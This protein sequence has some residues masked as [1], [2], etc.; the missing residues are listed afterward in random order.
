MQYLLPVQF[1]KACGL[2]VV[3]LEL[4][5]IVKEKLEGDYFYGLAASCELSKK[6]ELVGEVFGTSQ[7][8]FKAHDLVFNL[9]TRYKLTDHYVPLFSEGRS[10]FNSGIEEAQ[11]LSYLGIQ[12]LF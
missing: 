2:F 9:G 7:K 11:F 6:I 10:I 5:Y 8:D 4:S 12:F 1:A 3:N